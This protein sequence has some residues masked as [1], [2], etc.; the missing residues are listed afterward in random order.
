MKKLHP[1]LLSLKFVIV[2]L[3]LSQSKEVSSLTIYTDYH[4]YPWVYSDNEGQP[5]KGISLELIELILKDS[6]IKY[7][8]E[9]LPWPRALHL[10]SNTTDTCIF[11][12]ARTESR[13]NI[14]HW[15]A[16]VGY[17]SLA[18]FAS[19][20]S[21][22]TL[23]TLDDAK[24]YEIG[25]NISSIIYETLKKEN[26]MNIKGISDNNRMIQML[27]NNRLD[28]IALNKFEALYTAKRLNKTIIEK[29]EFG[30]SKLYLACNKKT[31]PDY[32]KILNNNFEQLLLSD[33]I[34][35]VYTKYKITQ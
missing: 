10:A 35:K 34:K 19:E 21:Q 9:T 26:F 12:T 27:T 31:N 33:K 25:I 4:Q 1:I 7:S 23:K 11:P 32:I 15:I 3:L 28:L 30:K 8:I 18:F 16:H 6:N 17:N 22:I 24:K 29:L 13:E 2:T 5:I 20:N 14:F